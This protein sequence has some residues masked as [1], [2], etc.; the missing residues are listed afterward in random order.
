M[1]FE[2]MNKRDRK[3]VVAGVFPCTLYLSEAPC[4]ER[5]R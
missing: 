5:I 2:R 3:R 1:D 4:F